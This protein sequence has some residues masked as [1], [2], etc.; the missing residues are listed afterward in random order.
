MRLLHH[1]M[2]HTSMDTIKSMAANKS[3]DGISVRSSDLL[4]Y[5]CLSCTAA[6]QK[7]MSFRTTE[8]TRED[9]VLKKL[10]STSAVSA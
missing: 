2:D 4:V 1:R 6:K 10:Q 3:V 7:R 5:D 9:Q 8:P